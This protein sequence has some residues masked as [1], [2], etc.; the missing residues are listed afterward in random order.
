V[1]KRF[2]MTSSIEVVVS[3]RA[4]RQFERILDYTEQQWGSS[5]RAA[6]RK[7]LEDAIRR[8]GDFPGIGHPVEGGPPGLREL[9]P[10]H[11]TIVYRRDPARVTIL[12]IRSHRRRRS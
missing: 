12:R 10:R 4:L 11:H 2:P 8:I 3:P 5:Q 1:A 7:V 9:V 6:Y